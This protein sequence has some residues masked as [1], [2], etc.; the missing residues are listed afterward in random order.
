MRSLSNLR[1]A[2]RRRSM[3][4]IACAVTTAAALLFYGCAEG[5]RAAKAPTARLG[6]PPHR[7]V[8][9]G[10]GRG[11]QTLGSLGGPNPS[12]A[13]GG[14]YATSRLGTPTAFAAAKAA[15]QP[16]PTR[17]DLV[18]GNPPLPVPRSIRRDRRY[19]TSVPCT[20]SIHYRRWFAT[21]TGVSSD[22]SPPSDE[23]P[24]TLRRRARR[25]SQGQ[26]C[27]AAA[28]GDIAVLDTK[29][30]TARSSRNVGSLCSC[31]PLLS[32]WRRSPWGSHPR[33][34][35]RRPS[36]YQP[37]HWLRSHR[38]SLDLVPRD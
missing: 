33:H 32:R 34:R 14:K 5:E 23:A 25:R 3:H 15:S 2:F 30:P 13:P 7:L 6:P 11:V 31:D 19:G 10:A 29:V 9:S 8:R 16:N 17:S 26:P 4:L 18:I 27:S 20:G 28:P 21:R 22:G 38:I 36:R 1:G 12:Q 35:P 37:R 24:L